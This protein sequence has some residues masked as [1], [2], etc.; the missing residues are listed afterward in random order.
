MTCKFCAKQLTVWWGRKFL[1]WDACQ[2]KCARSTLRKRNSNEEKGS[3]SHLIGFHASTLFALNWALEKIKS[4]VS[5]PSNLIIRFLFCLLCISSEGEILI[6]RLI[7]SAKSIFVLFCLFTIIF[8]HFYTSVKMKI[9][10]ELPLIWVFASSC[11]HWVTAYFW[12]E[13]FFYNGKKASNLIFR[14]S[15]VYILKRADSQLW[16]STKSMKTNCWDYSTLSPL[17]S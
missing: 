12:K 7:K 17:K 2:I 8:C 15:F 6:Q 13:K 10:P 5:C 16:L 3:I 11:L 9:S 14:L 1:R 4:V